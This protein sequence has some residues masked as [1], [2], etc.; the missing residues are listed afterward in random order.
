MLRWLRSQPSNSATWPGCSAV[1]PAARWQTSSATAS[2]FLR[3]INESGCSANS[4]KCA[5]AIPPSRS[6]LSMIDSVD[7]RHHRFD[8]IC[9]AGGILS[10]HAIPIGRRSHCRQQIDRLDCGV[11]SVTSH[12]STRPSP[13]GDAAAEIAR[14]MWV[15]SLRTKQLKL[16]GQRS[17]GQSIGWSMDWADRWLDRQQPTVPSSNRMPRLTLD[18]IPRRSSAARRRESAGSADHW[19]PPRDSAAM[20]AA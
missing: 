7:D 18:P 13:P 11:G 16:F 10:S 4:R 15:V 6:P 2:P 3:A 5:V 9:V 20:S 8:Q 1:T 14:K 17:A 19:E 12:W